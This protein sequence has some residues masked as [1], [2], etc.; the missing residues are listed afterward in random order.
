MFFSTNK[1]HTHGEDVDDSEV[2]KVEG[3]GQ[4]DRKP[5]VVTESIS[6]YVEKLHP[7][8]VQKAVTVLDKE[9]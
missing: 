6:E 2:A 3:S 5:K 9:I 8:P 1:K 7:K 4:A